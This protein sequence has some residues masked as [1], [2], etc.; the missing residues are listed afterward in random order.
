MKVLLLF[1]ERKGIQVPV[2]IETNFPE[3]ELLVNIDT[4]WEV[5]FDNAKR[6]PEDPVKM[7]PP[8]DWSQKLRMKGS[9][10]IR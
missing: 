6:G 9:N 5:S 8:E 2:K 4:P 7:T 3:P 1:S 10:I